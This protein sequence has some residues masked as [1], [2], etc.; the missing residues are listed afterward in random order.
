MPAQFAAAPKVSEA[1]ITE[2]LR[3]GIQSRAAAANGPD[4]G[5]AQTA[6]DSYLGL[7]QLHAGPRSVQDHTCD[8]TFHSRLSIQASAVFVPAACHAGAEVTHR[9]D[10]QHTAE[11]LQSKAAP[12][13]TTAS[14]PASSKAILKSSLRPVHQLQPST[15]LPLQQPAHPDAAQQSNGP[16]Q[17]QQNQGSNAVQAQLWPPPRQAGQSWSANPL[18]PRKLQVGV[19]PEQRLKQ[20][21]TLAQAEASGM[22]RSENHGIQAAAA[23][24]KSDGENRLPSVPVSACLEGQTHSA[25]HKCNIVSAK[26]SGRLAQPSKQSLKK[27]PTMP[28]EKLLSSC[29]QPSNQAELPAQKVQSGAQKP[30]EKLPPPPERVDCQSDLFV[31]KIQSQAQQRLEEL[32]LPCGQISNQS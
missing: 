6:A 24:A 23:Q 22:A 14:P 26:I 15:Q 19:C 11:M 21:V 30:L 5:K 4:H 27:S 9:M 31:Q 2:P 25:R 7:D 10:L 32:L 20:F 3:D 28:L 16:Q 8:A 17:Q 18:V 1:A 29:G 12:Q 13:Q